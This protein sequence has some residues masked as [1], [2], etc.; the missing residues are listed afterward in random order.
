[1]RLSKRQDFWTL[2]PWIL[3]TRTHTPIQECGDT[4]VYICI[5]IPHRQRHTHT[6][7][8]THTATPFTVYPALG[9]KFLD[10]LIMV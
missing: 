3:Y 6:K 4:Y 1:M 9:I 8:L 10:T 2:L 5:Y 7:P